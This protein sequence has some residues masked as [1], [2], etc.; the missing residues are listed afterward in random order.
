M[1]G[2]GANPTADPCVSEA[3]GHSRGAYAGL[4]ISRWSPDL[5]SESTPPL[6]CPKIFTHQRHKPRSLAKLAQPRIWGSFPEPFAF[7]EASP[8]VQSASSALVGSRSA[9]MG[10]GSASVT[11]RR[12]STP[13]QPLAPSLLR[14]AAHV[15][16][17]AKGSAE[18]A[19]PAPARHRGRVPSFRLSPVFGWRGRQNELRRIL[20]PEDLLAGRRAHYQEQRRAQAS[21]VFAYFITPIETMSI[22][23]AKHIISAFGTQAP[24]QAGSLYGSLAAVVE[25]QAYSIWRLCSFIFGLAGMQGPLAAPAAYIYAIFICAI[26]AAPFVIVFSFFCFCLVEV[27]FKLLLMGSLSPIWLCAALF[28]PTRPWAIAAARIVAGSAL[29]IPFLAVALGFTMAIVQ[30]KV[31]EALSMQVC[32][33]NKDASDFCKSAQLDIFKWTSDNNFILLLGLGWISV[34]CH[35]SARRLAGEVTA[36]SDP[37]TAT[38]LT[39]GAFSASAGLAKAASLKGAQI[40]ASAAQTV[41][42]GLLAGGNK[43]VDLAQHFL[44]NG[45]PGPTAAAPTIQPGASSGGAS[46]P[47]S[48]DRATTEA[49]AQ[50]TESLKQFNQRFRG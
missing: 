38:A 8:G 4:L 21:P 20:V 31:D 36:H 7:G 32:I 9:A 10:V 16:A 49:L 3:Q 2:G 5:C 27:L 24:S 35:L 25:E 29:S 42:G 26:I 47:V 18:D 13:T 40:T 28:A 30:P 15:A 46:G 41:G 33:E 14:L 34:L 12:I 17:P 37:G 44:G 43:A 6:L 39:A 50:F 11:A 48:F 22:E 23:L 1:A 19:R 45:N